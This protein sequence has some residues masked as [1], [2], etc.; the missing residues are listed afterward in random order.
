MV[1]MEQPFSLSPLCVVPLLVSFQVLHCVWSIGGFVYLLSS[2]LNY[3]G[4][5]FR[6]PIFSSRLPCFLLSFAFP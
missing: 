4:S 2:V 5:G 1:L 3:S 6:W